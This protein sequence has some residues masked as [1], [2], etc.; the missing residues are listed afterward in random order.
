MGQQGVESW[1]S[2][3]DTSRMSDRPSRYICRVTYQPTIYNSG[4]LQI[5][6]ITP[7]LTPSSSPT[8][9]RSGPF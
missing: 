1:S 8:P 9:Q 7:A 6:P 2:Y 4:R 3:H 5:Y